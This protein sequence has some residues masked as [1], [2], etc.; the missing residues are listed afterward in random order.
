MFKQEGYDLVGAAIEVYNEMGHGFLEDVYQECLETEI[1]DRGIP[2]ESQ[3]ALNIHYKG[4]KL[5]K[6]Y[7]PDLYVNGG[8]V[9]ELKAIKI[10]SNNEMAQL[11]NYLKASGKRVGYLINFGHADKLDWQRLVL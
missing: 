7:R 3:P 9:V 8:I 11:L 10:L 6:R 1:S 4:K 5:D 2:F